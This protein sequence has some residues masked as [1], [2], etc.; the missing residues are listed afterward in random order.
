[1][2]KLAHASIRGRGETALVRSAGSARINTH[3]PDRTK[4][5]MAMRVPPEGRTIHI[6][7]DRG[8]MAQARP[9][10]PRETLDRYLDRGIAHVG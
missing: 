1:M 10:D 6:S 4:C 5:D 2:M 7:E 3:R 9:A 8:G